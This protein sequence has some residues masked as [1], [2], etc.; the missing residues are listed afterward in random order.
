M[1]T[2]VIRTKSVEFMP[3]WL[4]FFLTISAIVWFFYGFLM[5]DIFVAVCS[6]SCSS[7]FSL[8]I[9]LSFQASTRC[10]LSRQLKVRLIRFIYELFT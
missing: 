7:F 4:S 10:K 1:Q 3:F 2:Q 9:F 8:A 5:K 6:L